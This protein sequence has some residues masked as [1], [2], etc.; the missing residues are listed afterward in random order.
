VTTAVATIDG[1][2]A[3]GVAHRTVLDARGDGLVIETL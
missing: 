3:L 1:V 2:R